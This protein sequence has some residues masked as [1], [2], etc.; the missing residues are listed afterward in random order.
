MVMEDNMHIPMESLNFMMLNVGFA[1]HNA[2]WN[3]KNVSSPFARI[4]YVRYSMEY[5]TSHSS[6]IDCV[7]SLDKGITMLQR[8]V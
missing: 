6:C 4:Y 2:D 3:W 7:Q 5:L 1:Q 8:N